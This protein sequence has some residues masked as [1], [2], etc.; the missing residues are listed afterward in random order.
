MR[1]GLDER[2]AI[3]VTERNILPAYIS[4]QYYD[5]SRNIAAGVSLTHLKSPSDWRFLNDDV[6]C[7]P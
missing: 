1:V 6:R 7:N 4:V 5:Q 3:I 2:S